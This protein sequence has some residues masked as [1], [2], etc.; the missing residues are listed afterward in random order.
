MDNTGSVFTYSRSSLALS[1]LSYSICLSLFLPLFLP[2]SAGGLSQ[3]VNEERF[4]NGT[5]DW[6]VELMYN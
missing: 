2:L 5:K 6:T 3:E 4:M 1:V